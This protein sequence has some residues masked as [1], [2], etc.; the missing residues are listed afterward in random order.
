MGSNIMGNTTNSKILNTIN[1]P[2][3]IFQ[4]DNY[5]GLNVGKK[6]GMGKDVEQWWSL[7]T[8]G[9]VLGRDVT[10][11]PSGWTTADATANTPKIEVDDAA[12]M[13]RREFYQKQALLASR[14]GT[15]KTTSL[16]VASDVLQTNRKSLLGGM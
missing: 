2:L 12:A 3:G 14:K 16:G 10:P 8:T 5:I 15:T 11:E 6:I 1:D 13:A 9:G 7:A 4:S